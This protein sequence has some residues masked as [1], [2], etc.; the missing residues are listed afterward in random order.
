MTVCKISH[1]EVDH[2]GPSTGLPSPAGRLL[3]AA[4]DDAAVLRGFD[5]AEAQDVLG[6]IQ[7]HGV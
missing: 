7:I 1:C 4:V 3:A 2:W 6:H 5:H